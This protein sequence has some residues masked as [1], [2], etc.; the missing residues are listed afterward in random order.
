MPTFDCHT[1]LYRVTYLY[2]QVHTLTHHIVKPAHAEIFFISQTLHPPNRCFQIN[3]YQVKL[4]SV[5][6]LYFGK[7]TLSFS[8]VA[9]NSALILSDSD[10]IRVI[11]IL[12]RL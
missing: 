2:I 7:K 4:M 1:H 9:S 5:T 10:L 3:P 11:C 12:M 6:I 8:R